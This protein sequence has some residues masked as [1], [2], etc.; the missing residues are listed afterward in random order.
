MRSLA[1]LHL[2]PLFVIMI[3]SMRSVSCFQMMKRLPLRTHHHLCLRSSSSSSSYQDTIF[4]LSSSGSYAIKT[5]VSV[6]RISGPKA[7]HCLEKLLT[8]APSGAQSHTKVS[9]PKPRYA[10]LRRIFD[11]QSGDTLDQALVLTFSS[12]NSFTGEDV[13]ELHTHGSRAVILGVFQALEY[14]NQAPSTTS[15]SASEESIGSNVE[16]MSGMKGSVRPAERGE[17]TRRA[18][19]NGKMDLTEGWLLIA[20]STHFS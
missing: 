17:F 18:F 4:A 6:I 19:E 8:K 7:F 20:Y 13:V 11:P 3:L 5:G 1:S 12:P 10:S 14:L 2:I 16:S 15:S 9:L